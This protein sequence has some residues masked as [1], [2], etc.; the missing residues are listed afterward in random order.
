MFS[1]MFEDLS[2]SILDMELGPSGGITLVDIGIEVEIGSLDEMFVSIVDVFTLTY[3]LLVS[4]VFDSIMG[5]SL[6]ETFPVRPAYSIT[7][8]SASLL[9]WY[10]LKILCVGFFMVEGPSIV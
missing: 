5:T 8:S 9:S 2:S 4:S 1:G 3:R 10:S 7:L 6:G